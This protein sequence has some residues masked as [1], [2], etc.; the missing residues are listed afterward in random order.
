VRFIWNPFLIATWK[1][2]LSKPIPFLFR[3]RVTF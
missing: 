2:N 3:I 1:Q